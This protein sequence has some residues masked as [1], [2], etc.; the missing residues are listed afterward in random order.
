RAGWQ[1]IH[2]LATRPRNGSN[3]IVS[4]LGNASMAARYAGG[5][6][7]RQGL[8]KGFGMAAEGAHHIRHAEDNKIRLH[9]AQHFV[10]PRCVQWQHGKDR[11]MIATLCNGVLTLLAVKNVSH[12][13]HKK[14]VIS[15]AVEKTPLWTQPLPAIS[16]DLLPPSVLGLLEPEGPHGGCAREGPHGFCVWDVSPAQRHGE[17]RASTVSLGKRKI[18]IPIQDK[19]TNP[20]Y[21]PYHRLPTVNLFTVSDSRSQTDETDDPWVFGLPLSPNRRVGSP[22]DNTADAYDEGITAEDMEGFVGQMDET[23]R[24][25]RFSKSNHELDAEDEKLVDM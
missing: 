13:Q 10:S 11:D 24:G 25:Q 20:S 9:P 21:M 19:D 8:S 4:T 15:P 5:R 18:R 17:R 14:T 7:V 16:S 23:L 12:T 22:Q 3:G 1:S 6:A 2:G